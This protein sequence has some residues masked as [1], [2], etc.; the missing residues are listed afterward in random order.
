[1]LQKVADILVVEDNPADVGLLR[2]ALRQT[3]V[4]Y[5]LRVVADG[6]SAIELLSSCTGPDCPDL[7]ILDLNLPR[8]SGY[9]VLDV[10]R[11]NSM[12]A[13]V[14]VIVMSSSRDE[15]DVERAYDAHANCFIVKPSELEDLLRVVLAIETFWLSVAE[16]PTH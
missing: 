4:P 7:V 10:I 1:M 12:T 8:R 2:E 3:S 5:R 13:A 9:E 14:P 6:A 15:A 11:S 16:L